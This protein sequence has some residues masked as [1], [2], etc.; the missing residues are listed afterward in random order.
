[1]AIRDTRVDSTT[2]WVF[3]TFIYDG[4]IPGANGYSKLRPVGLMW[5]NDPDLGPTQYA[6]GVRATQTRLYQP[7]QSIMRHTGWLGRLDGPV[8]NPQ[9]SSTWCHSTAQWPVSAAMTPPAGTPEGSSAWMLWFRNIPAS[10]SPSPRVAHRWTIL[11]SWR[12][13]FKTLL[14]RQT[15]AK[16]IR[17]RLLCHPVQIS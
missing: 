9:S 6:Q 17:R 11:C 1:M 12:A 14:H 15:H 7:T 5:G 3:G 8:D 10:V 13:A 4:R 16:P 2:G